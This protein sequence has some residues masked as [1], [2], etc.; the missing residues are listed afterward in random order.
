VCKFI[1][2]DNT[3]DLIFIDIDNHKNTV[4]LYDNDNDNE[5]P[6]N[7]IKLLGKRDYL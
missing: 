2:S 1:R 6:A 7:Y 4:T 3:L 5:D